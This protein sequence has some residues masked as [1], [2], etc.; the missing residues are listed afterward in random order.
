LGNFSIAF[1]GNFDDED[2]LVAIG[3]LTLG[4]DHEYFES[5]LGFW[6]LDEYEKSWTAGL[7]RLLDGAS[8]SC[9]ATSVTDPSTA[10]FVEIWPLYR[11][12]D[13]VYVQNRLI[14]MDQLPRA[15]D[16][17]APWESVE[18]RSVTDE[19]GRKISEWQ[20]SRSDIQE[21]LDSKDSRSQE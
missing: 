8:I 1:T 18:P 17:A 2:P 19:D 13:D 4:A 5:V 21:F 9:L 12:G 7:R 10:N 15:F 16:T 11:S 14:F 20:V 6:E 3:E